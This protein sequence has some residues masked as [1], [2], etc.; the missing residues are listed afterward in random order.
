MSNTEPSREDLIL[1][2]QAIQ[3]CM[4]LGLDY[5]DFLEQLQANVPMPNVAELF[6]SDYS[7]THIVDYALL[8]R[9]EWPQLSRDKLVDLVRKIAN[10]EGSEAEIQINVKIFEAN[11]RHPAKSGLIF[12]PEGDDEPTPEEIVDQALSYDSEEGEKRDD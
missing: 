9:A 12:Y 7:P 5:T 2:A 3:N 4:D 11:C 10:A 8:W 6:A 1:L